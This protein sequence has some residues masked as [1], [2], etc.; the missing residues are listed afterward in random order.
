MK[1]LTAIFF[2]LII[3]PLQLTAQDWISPDGTIDVELKIMDSQVKSSNPEDKRRLVASIIDGIQNKE[4]SADSVAVKNI[5]IDLALEPMKTSNTVNLIDVRSDAVI[6]LAS[7]YSP[8]SES[9]L[10]TII[11]NEEDEY[12]IMLTVSL[13]SKQTRIYNQ[14]LQILVAKRFAP[15]MYQSNRQ[16]AAMAYIK[17]V[18]YLASLEGVFVE[19]EVFSTLLTIMDRYRNKGIQ[20]RVLQL[21]RKIS[22]L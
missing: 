10:Y 1:R 20:E 3:L 8:E 7:I 19:T 14:A 5:L 21:S 18:E 2:T 11:K 17:Y 6:A 22:G 9:A 16:A 4:F 15:L 13:L 12:L